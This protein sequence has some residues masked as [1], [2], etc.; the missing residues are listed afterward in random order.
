MNECKQG[1]LS[2]P[3][4]VSEL[5]DHECYDRESMDSVAVEILQ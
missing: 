4:K 2:I 1:A 3:C 5:L